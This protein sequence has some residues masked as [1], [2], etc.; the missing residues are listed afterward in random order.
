MLFLAA[1]GLGFVAD[2][3]GKPVLLGYSTGS[4]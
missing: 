2:F 4:R 3:F 1:V